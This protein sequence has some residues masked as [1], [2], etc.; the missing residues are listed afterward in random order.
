MRDIE[1]RLAKIEKALEDRRKP[2]SD[3]SSV[4]S[5]YKSSSNRTANS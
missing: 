4:L 1:R 3:Y 2:K 5:D